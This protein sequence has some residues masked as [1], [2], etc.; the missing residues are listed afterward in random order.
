[1]DLT[2]CFR[3]RRIA[4]GGTGPGELPLT[5]PR[6]LLI[7]TRNVG[8]LNELREL[9]LDLPL[10]LFGLR[11]FPCV[12]TVQESGRTFVENASLKA[13][14][15]AQQIRLLTLADDSGL[16]VQALSGAP[17]VFSARYAGEFAS[18]T[19]RTNALL[20][21]LLT[22]EASKRTARFVSAVAIASN[23]G[24]ILKIAVGACEGHIASAPRGSSGF[25]YDPIFVPNG[26][27]LTFA[28]MEPNTKN[29]ISHRARAFQRAREYLQN[30]TSASS[31]R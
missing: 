13:V 8:K 27:E 12:E 21:K 19:T 5:T 25:G 24:K 9:L 18:D 28:E 7:A 22:V 1:V 11:D 6:S 2:I 31:A 23:E 17:G 16:E 4:G 20:A 3:L 29:Q 30:L 10:V 15:Y 14:G 26:Y